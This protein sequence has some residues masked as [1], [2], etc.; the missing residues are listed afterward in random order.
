[1]RLKILAKIKTKNEVTEEEKRLV[2]KTLEKRTKGLKIEGICIYGSRVS[3]YEKSHSDYDLI[4]AV[5]N[6]R[7][8]IRYQYIFDQIEI[9]AIFVDSN[10]LQDDAKN[11]ELG[12]FVVGRLLNPYVPIINSDFFYKIEY[13][14]KKRVIIETINELHSEYSF[15]IQFIRIPTNYF[16]FKRLKQRISIYPPVKYSY[17]MTYGG[18]QKNL[19]IKTSL[20]LFQICLR[21]LHKSGKIVYDN[22]FVRLKI[23]KKSRKNIYFRFIHLHRLLRHYYVHLLAGRVKPAIAQKE[24]LSKIKRN[25]E[26]NQELEHLNKPKKLLVIK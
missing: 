3:G 25:K 8:R 12:E 5:N 17:T 18:Q 22:K 11:A 9:S 24:L 15:L 21:E 2:L 14:Y 4:V 19:N 20:K 13:E 26:I 1:M 16:L 6:Y 23:E 7:P 10:A